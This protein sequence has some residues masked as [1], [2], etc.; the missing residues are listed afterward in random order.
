MKPIFLLISLLV[1]YCCFS[2]TWSS[3]CDSTIVSERI[4]RNDVY[5][6]SLHKLIA[7]NSPYLDSVEIPKIIRDSI[8]KVLYAIYNMPSSLLKDTIMSFF[9][10]SNFDSLLVY[11]DYEKDSVHIQHGS[12]TAS[13]APSVKR[14]HVFIKKDGSNPWADNDWFTGNFYNTSNPQIN[15]FLSNYGLTVTSNSSFNPS[16]TLTTSRALN[17]NGLAKK[18]LALLVGGS[19]NNV[20][21]SYQYV[22][23]GNSIQIDY[24]PLGLL[25]TFRN[26][27]GDCPVGC[28]HGRVWKFRVNTFTDCSV[29]YMGGTN[30]YS[31][32]PP[33]NG[34]YVCNRDGGNVVPIYFRNIIGEVKKNKAQIVW[35]VAT[36]SNMNY[37]EIEKSVMNSDFRESGRVYASS[38]NG[39]KNYQWLD[40][41]ELT[42]NTFYRIKA[43]EKG[44]KIIYSKTILLRSNKQEAALSISPNPVVNRQVNIY[45]RNCCIGEKSLQLY[46]VEGK[47][48]FNK[49]FLV[50]SSNSTQLVMLPS[51]IGRGSYIIKVK[52]TGDMNVWQ[53]LVFVE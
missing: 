17:T 13:Y 23:D 1:S 7:N 18:F 49:T 44:G 26:G 31:I 29:L 40:N 48:I 43:V 9:G 22:G 34:I 47:L 21:E 30:F 19:S 15:Q 38:L 51:V 45:F 52:A 16:Y 50:S 25:I 42:S 37:Y 46:S 35:D 6:I 3:N 27:C 11:R 5:E 33:P 14:L 8:A 32:Q 12:L 39:S 10:F 53:Q 28:T 20:S 2:Q 36:E 41:E 24:F 4:F